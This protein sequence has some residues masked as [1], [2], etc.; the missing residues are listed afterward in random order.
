MRI[1]CEKCRYWDMTGEMTG[2]PPGDGNWGYCS[3]L[4]SSEDDGQKPLGR[5]A[6]SF[7]H[8][9]HHSGVLTLGKFSCIAAEIR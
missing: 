3:Y 1:H 8:Y 7:G 9:D 4:N 5:I 6:Y 2:W